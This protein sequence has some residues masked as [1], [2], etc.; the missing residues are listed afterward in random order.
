MMQ[1]TVIPERLP[2]VILVAPDVRERPPCGTP[3]GDVPSCIMP[4]SRTPSA[5]GSSGQYVPPGD[6]ADPIQEFGHRWVR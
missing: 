1:Q 6:V 5:G 3:S 4:S 2:P